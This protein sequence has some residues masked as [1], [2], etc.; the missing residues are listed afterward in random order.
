MRRW[1]IA[2]V[3]GA[4]LVAAWAWLAREEVSDPAS[5]APIAGAPGVGSAAT[6]ASVPAKAVPSEASRAP[7]ATARMPSP[8]APPLPPE[9]APLAEAYDA[10]AARARAG[11]NAAAMRLAFDLTGCKSRAGADDEALRELDA[12]GP[13][14]DNPYA[15]QMDADS[16][17]RLEEHVAKAV[18][19]CR[20]LAP[21]LVEARGEWLLLAAE[22]GDAEAMVCFAAMPDEFAPPMFSDPWFDWSLRWRERATTFAEMAYAR[23]RPD[24][25]LV[26][27]EAHSGQTLSGI[28]ISQYPLAAVMRPDR[29][30]G[31]AYGDIASRI[32]HVGPRGMRNTDPYAELDEESRVRARALADRDAGRFTKGTDSRV[33][34]LPCRGLRSARRKAST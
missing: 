2:G 34:L 29:V 27:A 25:L 21:E 10:L 19:Y 30:R 33:E 6:P 16:R 24:I 11:D 7:A 20:G 12:V 3:V 13:A 31:A 28:P 26:L 1:M 15:N 23:G 18:A 8:A 14:V 32:G 17:R 9:D 5:D 22:R 4:L